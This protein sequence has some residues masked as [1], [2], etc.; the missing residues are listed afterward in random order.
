ML[1]GSATRAQLDKMNAGQGFYL[2]VKKI[3]IKI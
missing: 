1:T 3:I 2:I